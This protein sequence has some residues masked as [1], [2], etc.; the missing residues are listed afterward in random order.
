VGAYT[1]G[2]SRPQAWS[3]WRMGGA[4]CMKARMQPSQ[5]L[6]LPHGTAR[7]A[8]A[9]HMRSCMGAGVGI[10]RVMSAWGGVLVHGRCIGRMMRR[11]QDAR[12]HPLTSDAE[13]E[14]LAS[15]R[16]HNQQQCP[17]SEP[18]KRQVRVRMRTCSAAAP[19][20]N[21]QA[22]QTD[23]TR[24]APSTTATLMQRYLVPL[25]RSSSATDDGRGNAGRAEQQQ[26][27]QQQSSQQGR[28]RQARIQ[29]MRMVR[30]RA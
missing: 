28:L 20:T 4:T 1:C 14:G 12:T 30:E 11:M 3:D 5:L 2:T 24:G 19:G 25:P 16:G 23:R 8:S 18:R 7:Q 26:Q 29:E 10:G 15:Y 21:I 17:K 13:R 27:Q 22:P 9:R 6:V